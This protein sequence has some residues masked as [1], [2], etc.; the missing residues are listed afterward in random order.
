MKMKR[1]WLWLCTGYQGLVLIRNEKAERLTV[2]NGLHDNSVYQ[3][4]K[5]TRGKLYVF[6][7]QGMSEIIVDQNNNVSFKA[8]Y[9]P[10]NISQYGKFF[11]GIEAPDGTIWMGGEE[12]IAYLR[13]DSL[14]RFTF[15]GKQIFAALHNKR[16][17]G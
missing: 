12:G 14:H 6:G 8:H 9:Y 10:P 13:N 3:I 17:R 5:T 15:D 4:L 7:D 2:E 11:S 1:E 16:Q